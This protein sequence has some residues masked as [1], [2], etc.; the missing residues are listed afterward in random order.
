MYRYA[1]S[2][3]KL[4]QRLRNAQF[5]HGELPICIAQQIVEL[6]NLPHGLG[7]TVELKSIP[8]T[9]TRYI[10]TIC[11]YPLPKTN[12]EE[13]NFTKIKEIGRLSL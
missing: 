1:S 7:N 11:D 12:D 9:Y 6:W 4:G 2:N 10:H 8:D 3:I 5:L 13:V